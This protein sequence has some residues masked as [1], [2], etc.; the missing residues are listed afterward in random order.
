MSP[1]IDLG[2]PQKRH[3]GFV[4]LGKVCRTASVNQQCLHLLSLLSTHHIK[5]WFF[6]VHGSHETSNSPRTPCR[7]QPKDVLRRA[8][9]HRL[10][11]RHRQVRRPTCLHLNRY[12]HPPLLSLPRLCLRPFGYDPPGHPW[13]P[14]LSR[15][16]QRR[17]HRRSLST[18]AEAGGLSG[19]LSRPCGEEKSAVQ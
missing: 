3:C 15:R 5:P 4:Y 6:Y 1:E 2:S 10:H 14:E 8:Q 19:R 16:G 13:R 12:L 11:H 7:R 18:H 9:H 17:L